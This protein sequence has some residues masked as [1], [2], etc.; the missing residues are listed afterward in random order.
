MGVESV[1]FRQ[2]F[3]PS[4]LNEGVNGQSFVTII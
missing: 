1:F 3:S 4:F 2:L